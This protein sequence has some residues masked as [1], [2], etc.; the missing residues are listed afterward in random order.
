MAVSFGQLWDWLPFGAATS[1]VA[2]PD[3]SKQHPLPVVWLLGKTGAGKSSV[4]RALTGLT[5]AEVGNGYASCTR[6]AMRFDH[7][8]GRPVMRFLDTRGL[9]EA[10]YEP[11]EDL[12]AA[13]A[14][15]HLILVVA[16]LDDP[17]QGEVAEVLAA[18]C[19]R[20]P[21]IRL[22]VA[23]TGA[24]L[25]PDLDERRRAREASQK[26]FERAARR[27]L[28]WVELALATKVLAEP[29]GD[30]PAAPLLPLLAETMPEV[31]LLLAREAH[32]EGEPAVWTHHRAEV[33]W[34]AGSA[35]AADVAPVVGAAAVPAIQAAMLTRLA[36]CYGVEWS[37]TRML[38]FGAAL[39]TGV[40]LSFGAS[41]GL[42]QLVKLVPI[43]GQTAGAAASGAL[44]FAA[45][46]ALGR[47]AAYF[48]H[49]VSR[50]EEVSTETLRALY[51]DALKQGRS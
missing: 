19:E 20:D 13:E 32:M 36:T 24:D 51:A 28:P 14:A 40:A 30:A 48:L 37:R 22:I 18:I 27:P 45:T 39:G 1:D 11:A 3:R 33:L 10:G 26:R 38:E 46:F 15:S 41:F 47:A 23:H 12:S 31:A 49:S 8:T 17:V 50:N 4:I 43:V 7:P 42:R 29:D 21:N 35:G 44:S 6:T 2:E 9:G 5:E 25:V 34:F 16:R